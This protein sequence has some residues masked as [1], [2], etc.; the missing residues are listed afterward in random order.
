ME[1]MQ[2]YVGDGRMCMSKNR[3]EEGAKLI[4]APH[5]LN[6]S[7]EWKKLCVCAHESFVF[8]RLSP[9]LHTISVAFATDHLASL[10]SRQSERI[11]TEI[12]SYQSLLT[13]VL[14]NTNLHYMTDCKHFYFA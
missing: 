8:R 9:P 7:N 10:V 6:E 4:N 5:C 13:F 14:L 11:D 12:S 3:F 2:S 1:S